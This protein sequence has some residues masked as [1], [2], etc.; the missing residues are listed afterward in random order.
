MN[1]LP[2]NK[3]KYSHDKISMENIEE[4][5]NLKSNQG[6]MNLSSAFHN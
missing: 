3:N 6:S 1:E 2:F 5:Q 4:T